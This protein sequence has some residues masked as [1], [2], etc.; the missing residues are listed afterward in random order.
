VVSTRL[1]PRGSWQPH[2]GDPCGEQRRL[3][4]SGLELLD[5]AT[6]REL[7]IGS[8]AH[9]AVRIAA[10]V[11]GPDDVARVGE[12]IM[13]LHLD[14]SDNVLP[15]PGDVVSMVS[16]LPDGL[17]QPTVSIGRVTSVGNHHELGPIAFAAVAEKTSGLNSL[18]VATEDGGQTYLIAASSTP[19]EHN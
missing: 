12:C 13:L 19:V 11:L 17:P 3:E 5:S 1:D 10:G 18:V 6:A 7:K 15:K 9:D 14:G 2:Y 16:R 4:A 8:W